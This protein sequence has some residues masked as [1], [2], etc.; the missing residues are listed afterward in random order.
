MNN[1]TLDVTPWIDLA[2]RLRGDALPLDLGY[3]LFAAVSRLVPSLHA[4]ERWGI[5]PVLGQ[6]RGPGEL[7]LTD[8]SRL[9]LRLP[10]TAIAAVLPLAGTTLDVDGHRV[11]VGIPEIWP[12]VPA[13]RLRARIVII[14]GF[15][16]D[17]GAFAA[18]VQRQLKERCGTVSTSEPDIGRRRVLRVKDHTVVGFQVEVAGLSAEASIQIQRAGLGGRRHMGA[19]LFVPPRRRR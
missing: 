3:A 11:M 13:P 19:G 9:R 4:T 10:S 8:R 7:E 1:P 6:R 15:A 17:E 12:L 18:A 14:K 2:F 5:H 16:D